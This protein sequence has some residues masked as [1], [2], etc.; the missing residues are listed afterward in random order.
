MR[1]EV[2]PLAHRQVALFV[3]TEHLDGALVMSPADAR[4]LAEQLQQA[5]D[6]AADVAGAADAPPRRPGEIRIRLYPR[7]NGEWQADADHHRQAIGPTPL[8][9]LA[10]L[11]DRRQG[12]P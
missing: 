9:A 3:K 5:A 8:A 7:M 6:D 10:R 12:E 1:L 4:E 11:F 2:Q